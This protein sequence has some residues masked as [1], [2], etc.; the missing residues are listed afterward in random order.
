MQRSKLCDQLTQDHLYFIKDALGSH[1]PSAFA[2]LYEVFPVLVS[3]CWTSWNE[4]FFDSM[5]LHM[6]QNVVIFRHVVPHPKCWGCLSLRQPLSLRPCAYC[7][8]DI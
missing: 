2:K 1:R 5:T 4:I 8:Y 3:P 6:S 7:I